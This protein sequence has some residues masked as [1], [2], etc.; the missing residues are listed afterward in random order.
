MPSYLLDKSI[1][2]EI[3]EALHHVEHRFLEN[4]KGVGRVN[5]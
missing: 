1:V 5:R 2:R 4:G 3:V